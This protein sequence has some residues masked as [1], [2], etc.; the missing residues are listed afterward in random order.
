[1]NKILILGLI[2]E[3]LV[4]SGC[5]MQSGNVRMDYCSKFCE[6]RNLT[7]IES[8]FVSISDCNCISDDGLLQI[9]KIYYTQYNKNNT[10]E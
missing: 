9:Y 1:M 3:L 5:G 8:N 10:V 6:D 2:L 7:L 4:L